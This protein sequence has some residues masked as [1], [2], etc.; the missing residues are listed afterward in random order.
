M[1]AAPAEAAFDD[2]NWV[3]EVKWD[4]YRAIAEVEDGEVHLYSRNRLSFDK[5]FSPIV[6]SLEHLGHEAVLDGEIVVVDR[7]GKSQFQLLQGYRQSGPGTLVYK[8]FDL[9]YLDG[10]DLRKLPLLRRKEILGPLIKH[11]PNVLM[12]EHIPEH[13]RAFFKAVAERQL[14]GVVAKDGRSSY[15]AGVRSRT[16]LKIKTQLRQDAVIGGFTEQKDSR[17]RL[18]ALF[19]GVCEDDRLIYIGRAGTGFTEKDLIGL[20]ARVEGL[21]QKACPFGKRPRCTGV[22]HWLQ[23][24]LAC[25]V[26]FIEWTKEGHLRHPVYHGLREKIDPKTIRREQLQ[27]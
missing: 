15:Q 24:D 22:V 25:E 12:S 20:R 2:P 8:V 11:L 5:R 27:S 3:F 13:G 16:W 4:G 18:G 10:H 17:N 1:L 14:E 9:L 23:P 26:S 6:D 21:I 19:L 7:Q